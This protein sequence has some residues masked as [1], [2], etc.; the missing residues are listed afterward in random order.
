MTDK[1][2]DPKTGKELFKINDSNKESFTKDFKKRKEKKE[3]KDGTSD[4][5]NGRTE[6]EPSKEP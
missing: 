2:I 5:R 3:K 1:F 6:T 4:N